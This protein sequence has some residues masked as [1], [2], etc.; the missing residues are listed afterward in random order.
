MGKYHHDR[1]TSTFS[2]TI[3]IVILWIIVIFFVLKNMDSS[4]VGSGPIFVIAILTAVHSIKIITI[5]TIASAIV[6]LIAGVN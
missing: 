3:A 4:K 6:H 2:R 5:N 1:F